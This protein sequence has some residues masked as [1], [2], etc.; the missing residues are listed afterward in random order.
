MNTASVIDQAQSARTNSQEFRT[1]LQP[2]A[3]KN[4]IPCL[5]ILRGLAVL[6]ILLINI[7]FF[8]MAWAK[9]SN[10]RD[11]TYSDRPN[12]LVWLVS[13]LIA[14][15][16]F[17]AILSLLFG[18]G[19]LLMTS[20]A[21][22]SGKNSAVLHYR[23][24]GWL[25]VFGLAH[26]YL[27]WSGDI[28]VSYAM[29]GSLA[30]L[31]R[32]LRPSTL[33]V[34]SFSLLAAG[35]VLSMAYAIWPLTQFAPE[36]AGLIRPVSYAQE[37][38]AFRGSWV[39]QMTP[40]VQMAVQLETSEFVIYTFWRATGLMLAGM[41][42]LKLGVLQG[43]RSPATYWR[44]LGVALCVG[45]PVSLYGIHFASRLGRTS[46][47]AYVFGPQFTYWSSLMVSAGWVGALILASRNSAFL[48]CLQRIAAVGRM[49]LTNYLMQTLICTTIFY[50]HGF[51]LFGKVDRVGQLVIVIAI[52]ILQLTISPIWL[53]HFLY[54]PVEWLW[55]CL[56]YV[57]REPFSR[58]VKA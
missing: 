35:S 32:K 28:L 16:K 42:L 49:A 2:V 26:A 23:R 14:E 33:F 34:L 7:Q 12:H 55:R 1:T 13:Q 47:Y 4:R 48:P 31:C 8:A 17:M 3:E 52:W 44:M 58:A 21:E 39:T 45:I 22:A 40:R 29:C 54:G 51:G 10:L 6:G 27:L 15:Q 11:G 9:I 37:I 18:A 19:I 38:A 25:T 30:Y 5:D 56:T 50:G 36:L 41:A 46:I 57:R 53:K 43:R 20:R 24:M